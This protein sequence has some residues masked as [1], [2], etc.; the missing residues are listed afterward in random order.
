VLE[1]RIQTPSIVVRR[2]VYERLGGF[3]RRLA[4]AGEDWEMW[5]RIAAEFPFWYEVE[6]LALYRMRPASLSGQG[7]RTSQYARDLTNVLEIAGSYLPAYVPSQVAGELLAQ[8]RDGVALTAVRDAGRAIERKE[9]AAA[10]AHIRAALA[11]SRSF[12]VIRQILGLAWRTL[13]L[14]ARA[15]VKAAYVGSVGSSGR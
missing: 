8:A 12:G 9:L 6:P 7:R 3:D 15:R 4:C 10:A 11:C 5:I 2:D 13:A 14:W 1:Q